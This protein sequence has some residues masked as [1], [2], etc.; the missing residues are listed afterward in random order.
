MLGYT[1]VRHGAGLLSSPVGVW[2]SLMGLRAVML[3]C[4]RCGIQLLF[5]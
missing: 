1:Q 2:A 3:G 5:M 4:G